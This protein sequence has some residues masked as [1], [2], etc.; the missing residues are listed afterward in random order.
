MTTLIKDRFQIILMN[1]LWGI[2]FIIG[3]YKSVSLS[4]LILILIIWN[5]AIVALIDNLISIRKYKEIIEEYK[6]KEESR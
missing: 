2:I 4:D 3:I 5:I 6:E 1:I